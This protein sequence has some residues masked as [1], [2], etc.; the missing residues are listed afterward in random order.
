MIIIKKGFFIISIAISVITQSGCE[1]LDGLR[2]KPETVTTATVET[3]SQPEPA[4]VIESFYDETSTWRPI[5]P[6][7]LD[8]H[9]EESETLLKLL[10]YSRRLGELTP[11]ELDHEFQSF[12]KHTKEEKAAVNMRLQQA[13][14]LSVPVAPY[15]DNQR[16]KKILAD[17]INSGEKRGLVLREY[18]YSLLVNIEQREKA[19]QQNLQLR[20][21]LK[22]EIERREL[23]EKKR[24]LLE[25]KL[26]ALKS[27]EESI[28]Q[29][30]NTA[31]EPAP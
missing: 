13:L 27:I 26:E 18:A 15:R 6:H 11:K 9:F 10:R 29:R 22:K 2:Q 28:T 4:A 12:Q 20:K 25:Q 30:Q 19:E 14:L 5:L 21:S 16:A 24:D 31:E 23:L 7:E 8:A 3:E 17:V 1:I